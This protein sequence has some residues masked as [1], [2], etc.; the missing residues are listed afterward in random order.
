MQTRE[1]EERSLVFVLLLSFTE[2]AS[3]SNSFWYSY[4]YY[5]HLTPNI[6]PLSSWF[7]MFRSLTGTHA[8]YIYTC[9]QYRKLY[10]IYMC[11]AWQNI[12]SIDICIVHAPKLLAY[13][14]SLWSSHA[15]QCKFGSTHI[16]VYIKCANLGYSAD[17]VSSSIFERGKPFLTS[18]SIFQIEPSLEHPRV[19]QTRH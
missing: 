6:V 1:G 5:I 8:E 18:W 9:V 2:C 17:P 3:S 12:K 11:I 4:F 16:I 15:Y 19:F 10:G 7:V 14:V 13:S